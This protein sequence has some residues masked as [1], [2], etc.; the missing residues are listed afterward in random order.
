MDHISERR[1]FFHLSR[2]DPQKLQQTEQEKNN[3]D[4]NLAFSLL[5]FHVFMKLKMKNTLDNT[6]TPK[7][8]SLFF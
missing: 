4:E 3:L 6:T 1:G 2:T 8:H 7:K 5:K